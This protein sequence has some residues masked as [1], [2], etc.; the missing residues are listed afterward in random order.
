LPTTPYKREDFV[1]IDPGTQVISAL[2]EL[3]RQRES[4]HL[5]RDLCV[6]A[7]AKLAVAAGY[8]AGVSRHSDDW[9]HIEVPLGK[10]G[11]MT[12]SLCDADLVSSNDYNWALNSHGYIR[13]T[14]TDRYLHQVITERMFPDYLDGDTLMPGV[15]D[16]YTPDHINRDKLNNGR[17]NLRL[18]TKR[19]QNLN[20]PWD[21]KGI[22]KHGH[23][24]RAYTS[25]EGKKTIIGSYDDP[26]QA[27]EALEKRRQEVADQ[28]DSDGTYLYSRRGWD[29][30]RR[31]VIFAE[32]PSGTVSWHVHDSALETAKDLQVYL[33]G[34]SGSTVDKYSLIADFHP[35]P[36][37]A[38][39][40]RAV[41]EALHGI[42]T[43]HENR[44]LEEAIKILPA[45]DQ[46]K[47]ALLAYKLEE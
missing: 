37:I 23:R 11:T 47:L 44:R 36:G 15:P 38:P 5:E 32:L 34:L 7:V 20:K 24:F 39:E 26:I 4:Y 35:Q 31:N 17:W 8:K 45:A 27:R 33:P 9:D 16:G 12:L 19:G 25:L 1:M 2:Q 42:I 6:V 29:R 10:E 13:D 3:V 30:K 28:A 14:K 21:G 40:T 46:R 22:E 43:M 41:S 18:A